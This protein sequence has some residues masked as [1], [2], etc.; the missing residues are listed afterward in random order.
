MAFYAC[1][2]R[3][4]S[5]VG[6]LSKKIPLI[7]TKM[8][9]NVQLNFNKDS[10]VFA[11]KVLYN[12]NVNQATRQP[13]ID[14]NAIQNVNCKLA[15][16]INAYS[17]LANNSIEVADS[18]GNTLIEATKQSAAGNAITVNE[19]I[20]NLWA[21]SKFVVKEKSTNSGI[22]GYG[23]ILC[24]ESTDIMAISAAPSTNTHLTGVS[25]YAKNSAFSFG[26]YSPTNNINGTVWEEIT[27]NTSG[28]YKIYLSSLLNGTYGA[29]GWTNDRRIE[30]LLVNGNTTTSLG[31]A[32]SQ[33]LYP[34]INY[35]QTWTMS[36]SI[37][38]PSVQLT[39]GQKLRLK[40]YEDS[41]TL[42]GHELIIFK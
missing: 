19:T 13:V 10:T 41:Y 32:G 3:G 16:Y 11:P 33:C 29:S 34:S 18:S 24:D 35:Q 20:R 22:T 7:I 36:G 23:V 27:V 2:T 21:N 6:S 8:G 28:V 4:G 31:T 17:A 15:V 25:T 40:F 37:F 9:G 5:P 1:T 39:A 14:I 42:H 38:I 12:V 30:L 26:Q